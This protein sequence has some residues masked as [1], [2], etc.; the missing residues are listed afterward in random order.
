MKDK[1]IELPKNVLKPP[2]D[3]LFCLAFSPP[4]QKIKE[5]STPQ[6]IKPDYLKKHNPTSGEDVT[7][8]LKRYFVV[9]IDPNCKL[10]KIKGVSRGDEIAP[11][12]P[13]SSLGYDPVMVRDFY[14]G[15][16][17]IV[18]HETEIGGF[19]LRADMPKGEE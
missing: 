2:E 4:E 16:D 10:H 3:R 17:Y 13:Q 12:I 8:D 1:T 11:F 6:I 19:T 14:T 9:D 18:M 15:E 7:I 5:L